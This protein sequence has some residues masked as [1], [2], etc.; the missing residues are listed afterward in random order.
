MKKTIYHISKIKELEDANQE[1]MITI[2]HKLLE[3]VSGISEL[4]Y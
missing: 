1:Q 2:V 3:P 4:H